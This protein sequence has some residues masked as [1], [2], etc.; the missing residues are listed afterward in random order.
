[1]FVDAIDEIGLVLVL[2]SSRQVK[3][4]TL[5]DHYFI[6]TTAVSLVANSM[7]TEVPAVL[8]GKKH[9]SLRVSRVGGMLDTNCCRWS[10]PD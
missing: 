8:R 7:C 3:R 4:V 6:D 1:M 5:T 2:S 10:D 9:V